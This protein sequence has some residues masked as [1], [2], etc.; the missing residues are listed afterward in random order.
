[1][2]P[3]ENL[4]KGLPKDLAIDLPNDVLPTPGGPTRQSIGPFGFLTLD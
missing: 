3:R 1:M 2:P 4:I